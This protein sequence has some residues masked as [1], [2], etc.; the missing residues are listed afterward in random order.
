MKLDISKKL[1]KLMKDNNLSQSALSRETGVPQPTINRILRE[2]TRDPRRNAVVR[3]A[4]FFGITPE[5]LYE[6]SSPKSPRAPTK[7]TVE[8]IYKRIAMLSITERA[9]LFDRVSANLK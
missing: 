7:E 6:L 2:M 5:S 8:E 3:I 9:Q 4:N 1:S